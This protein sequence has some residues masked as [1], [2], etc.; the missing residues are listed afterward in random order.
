V[1]AERPELSLIV[2]VVDGGETLERCL[3]ALMGQENSPRLE[4]II[5]YDDTIAE[6]GE[7]AAKYPAYRFL[8]LGKLCDRAPANAYEQ[9][10]LFDRRRAEGLLVAEG[11]LVAMIEDRGWPLPTWA[12]AM[13][14]AHARFGDG[15]I[16]GAIESAAKGAGRWAAF[17]LDFG[18]YQA[19]FDS[20]DPEF[21]SDTNICYKRAALDQVK[22]LWREMY[23]ES[24]VNWALR[25]R[26]VGLRL[27]AGP[28][29]VQQRKPMG[30]LAMAM[31]RMHWGR[32][33]AQVRAHGV[34]PLG[35]L[36][37]I[38]SAPILPTVL[39]ARH[40][41]R[42]A[43]LGRHLFDFAKATPMM[44]YLLGFWSLGELVGYL[45]ADRSGD[46]PTV[47]A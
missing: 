38:A 43:R 5:P 41:R 21:V 29:T 44:L 40:L 17:F 37:W 27:E 18:R 13:A 16:G 32:N 30:P 3:D 6:V 46:S 35:R 12:R 39:Y 1:T 36:K 47:H 11:D 42:Q 4:V 15:V 2:T 24:E 33:F 7:L 9:H 22:D 23:H 31:E 8:N 25:D 14:D 28:R 34:A 45:E 19:P 10:N 20:P 26:K